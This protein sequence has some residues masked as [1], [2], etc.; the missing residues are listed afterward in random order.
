M[1]CPD[2][3]LTVAVAGRTAA[4]PRPE[5]PKTPKRVTELVAEA[6]QLFAERHPEKVLALVD[7]ILTLDPNNADAYYQLKRYKDALRLYRKAT[8]LENANPGELRKKINNLEVILR[9]RS[10]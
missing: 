5:E 1:L 7:E 10:L 4:A 6:A 9:E 8:E 3:S 2:G